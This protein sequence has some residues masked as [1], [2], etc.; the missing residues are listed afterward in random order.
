[1]ITSE[2]SHIPTLLFDEVDS[3]VGG[4]VAEIVGRKM[5]LLGKNRQVFCITHLPQVASQGHQHLKVSKSQ[6]AD[7]TSTIVEP[8]SADDRI[9]EVSRMLGGLNITAQTRAHATEMIS[10]AE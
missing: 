6:S 2:Y 7:A 5:R 9:E 4:A 8:L 10:L 3:G 1:M